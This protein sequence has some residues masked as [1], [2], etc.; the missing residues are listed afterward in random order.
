M[1]DFDYCTLTKAWDHVLKK[2]TMKLVIGIKMILLEW[3]NSN[4]KLNSLFAFSYY[5]KFSVLQ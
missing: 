2:R 4:S 1:G 3:K 5:L